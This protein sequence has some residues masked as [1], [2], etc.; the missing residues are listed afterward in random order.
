MRPPATQ[1][2]EDEVSTRLQQVQYL[3]DTMASAEHVHVFTSIPVFC[4]FAGVLTDL[5]VSADQIKEELEY[6]CT[7]VG[8]LEVDIQ[9]IEYTMNRH[10]H[11]FQFEIW[12][13]EKL[14]QEHQINA[15]VTAKPF[16]SSSITIIQPGSSF[17]F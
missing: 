4:R 10:E 6:I 11:P 13:W 2:E 9:A 3:L 17:T 8:L 7:N 14:A 16:N 5:K 1:Q 15:L 12:L